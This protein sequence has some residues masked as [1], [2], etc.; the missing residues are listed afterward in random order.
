M[1]QPIII[2]FEIDTRGRKNIA[3]AVVI[4]N[5]EGIWIH[6]SSDEFSDSF[7]QTTAPLRRCTIP[8]YALA[9]GKYVVDVF[10]GIRNIELFE[11]ITGVLSF[12]VEYSGLLSDRITGEW[13]GLCGPGLLKW[14][15][16]EK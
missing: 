13:K 14:Q 9:K 3:V 10:L 6:H 2:D 5:N 15:H 8:P 1:H 4:Q 7:S 16:L 12:D 11:N